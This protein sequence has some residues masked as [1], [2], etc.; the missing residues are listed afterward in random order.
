[1]MNLQILLC[2]IGGQ[3]ILFA[4]RILSE[5]AIRMGIPVIGSETH[6]MSQR[7]GSVTSHL[8]IG[9]HHGPLIRRGSADMIFCFEKSELIGNLTFLKPAGTIY[10][11]AADLNFMPDRL[12]TLLKVRD[13]QLHHFDAS[14][15]ALKM[16]APVVL[17]LI[18]IG[19]AAG[20]PD[21][22]LPEATIR[23]VVTEISPPRFRDLNIK[24]FSSGLKNA[25][26]VV[27]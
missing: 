8:K 22:P 15:L 16:K 5:T 3:G 14:A 24:A 23:E 4:T 18:L 11:D 2:G 6:G 7:G 26:E 9:R 21:F 19:F 25:T 12:H 27:L 13:V 20:H 1:M 10:L 17:N